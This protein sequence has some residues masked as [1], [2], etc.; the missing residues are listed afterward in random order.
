[1]SALNSY[2]PGARTLV[3]KQIREAIEFLGVETRNKYEIFTPEGQPL[4][5][6]EERKQ[7]IFSTLFRQILRHWRTFTLDVGGLQ[8]EHLFQF[9]HP[10][11]IFFQRLELSDQNGTQ[12]GSMERQLSFTLSKIF[13]IDDRHGSTLQM[14]A[15]FWKIWTY[16]I[17]RGET[18]VARIQKKWG[19]F[20]TEMFTDSDTFVI[21]YLDTSLTVSE[22]QLIIG[23]ALL[24]DIQYFEDNQGFNI[25]SFVDRS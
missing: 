17:Y 15:P 2:L 10:F 24:I 21:E 7:G 6:A 19:N 11:R 9:H 13:V 3:I 5:R 23:A 12:V 14:R 16:P 1:M 25:W 8:G 4:A 22:R 20:L 18:E